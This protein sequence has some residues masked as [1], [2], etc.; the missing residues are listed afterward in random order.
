V[1]L[2]WDVIVGYIKWYRHVSHTIIQNPERRSVVATGRGV[3]VDANVFTQVTYV[4]L[5]FVLRFI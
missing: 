4:K 1:T 3:D 5:C 2:L